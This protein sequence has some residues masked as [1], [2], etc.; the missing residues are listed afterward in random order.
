MNKKYFIIIILVNN[1]YKGKHLIIDEQFHWVVSPLDE[2]K[3]IGLTRHCIRERRPHSRR[4]VGFDPQAHCEGVHLRQ[5]LFHFSI[6][7][8]GPQWERQ[9]KFIQGSVFLFTC[10]YKKSTLKQYF[11]LRSQW[12]G[13]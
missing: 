7:V 12:N 2:Y 4:G 5:A 3:L 1:I 8:V 10:Q 9:L 13:K 6:H 11:T